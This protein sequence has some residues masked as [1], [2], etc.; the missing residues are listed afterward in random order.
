M[1]AHLSAE[2]RVNFSEQ[3]LLDTF[4]YN[5][6][7]DGAPAALISSL[8]GCSVADAEEF[9]SIAANSEEIAR[10]YLRSVE[11]RMRPVR[12]RRPKRVD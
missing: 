7:V 5:L 2:A 4:A 11:Q 3:D 8:R 12:R 9:I 6:A 1:L 10:V